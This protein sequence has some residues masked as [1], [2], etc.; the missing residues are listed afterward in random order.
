MYCNQCGTQNPDNASFCSS[1]GSGLAQ[2]ESASTV[3]CSACGAENSTQA[4]RCVQCQA[5]L[6][7]SLLGGELASMGQ[8]AGSWVIDTALQAIPYI[9]FLFQVINWVMFRRGATIGLKLVKARIVRDNG[10][11]SGFFHTFVRSVAA[12]LSLIPLGL[13]YW[14]AFWDSGRRTWHDK[15]MHTYVLR[16]TEALA[17]REGSS[18]STAV[19]V[20]WVLLAVVVIGVLLAFAI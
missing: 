19:L 9:D 7:I 11:L 3:F 13:G 6:P 15:I 18:S 1:C 2:Q 17:S 10:D 4:V 5:A 12:I 16:D 14:W 20:F 8:R